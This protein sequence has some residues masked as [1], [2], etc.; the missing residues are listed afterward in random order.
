[1]TARDR[2]ADVLESAAK[3]VTGPRRETYGHYQENHERIAALWSAYL[4]HPIS[5]KDAALMMALL[6][7]SRMTYGGGTSD[8]AIDAAA[9]CAIA[10]A[11]EK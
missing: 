1:M 6:K 5:A 4:R 10:G 2:A 8:N 3:L 11:L 7:I 9:Y